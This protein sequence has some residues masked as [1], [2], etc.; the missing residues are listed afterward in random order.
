MEQRKCK[1]QNRFNQFIQDLRLTKDCFVSLVN[2][3][4]IIYFNYH[5]MILA[6]HLNYEQ[7]ESQYKADKYHYIENIINAMKKEY[8]RQASENINRALRGFDKLWD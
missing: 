3:R 1:Y 2:N 6:Y 4:A 7:F 5:E 8:K